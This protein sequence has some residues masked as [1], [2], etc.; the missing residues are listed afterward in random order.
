MGPCVSQPGGNEPFEP[1]YLS[2]VVAAPPEAPVGGL[3][4]RMQ[5]FVDSWIEQA[6]RYR[7]DSE[8]IVV[9][10]SDQEGLRSTLRRPDGAPP[11]VRIVEVPSEAFGQRARGAMLDFR[12]LLNAGIRRARGEFILATD[13]S[14]IFSNELIEFLASRRLAK[15]KMY[16]MDRHGV[17]GGLPSGATLDERLA[18]C[19]NHATTLWAREGMFTLTSDGLRQNA[20]DDI[21]AFDSGVNF[22]SGW[23]PAEQH[24]T[25]GETFRWIH[26]DAEFVARVPNGGGIL[27]FDV[28]PGPGLCPLPQTLQ[29]LDGH[30]SRVA[31]WTIDGRT[32]VALAVPT[33][34]QGNLRKFQIHLTDGG[35]AALHDYRILNLAVFRCDWVG[36]N[37]ARGTA[38]PLTAAIRQNRVTL[39]RLLGNLLNV[40]GVWQAFTRGPKV[41]CR[42]AQLLA[43]RGEDIFEAGIEF[44]LG[45][46]WYC[47][48]ESGEERFRWVSQD[49]RLLLQMPKTTS[50]LALLAEPAPGRDS[51]V[52]VVRCGDDRGEVIARSAIQGLTYLEFTVPAAP[53]AIAALCISS[54]PPAS[55]TGGDLRALS[56]RIFACGAGVR[57]SA[58]SSHWK[59][60]LTLAVDSKPATQD[61]GTALEASKAQ[62]REMGRP[63][64]LHTNA[65][66]DFMLMS[67]EHWFD[68]RGYSELDLPNSHLDPLFCYAAHHSGAREEVLHDPLRI[69]RVAPGERGASDEMPEARPDRAPVLREDLLWLIAQMRSL[70]A[71]VIFNRHDWGLAEYDLPEGTPSETMRHSPKSQFQAG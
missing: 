58:P 44:Q 50:C 32:T 53:G 6:R 35:G 66:R 2:L 10:P 40:R 8:L 70:H 54:E 7:L 33:A 11:R 15:G 9:A 19:R 12:T 16:R 17:E 22:G 64:Y 41:A 59:G 26:G 69:Y 30:G 24:A 47:R 67:R 20:R 57:K 56:F 34:E 39:Q 49:A 46:G 14:V 29:I 60:W 31:E 23:C 37:V 13:I 21:A 63:E 61:W 36:P 42:A 62:L 27:V 68:V 28:A 3:L 55:P 71:P 4:A 1:P 43:K 18:Y 45:P 48:E 25:T 5:V 51:T 65:C 38:P 52:V